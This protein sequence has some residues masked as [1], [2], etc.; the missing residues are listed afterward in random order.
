MIDKLDNQ[1]VELSKKVAEMETIFRFEAVR[2]T[3][4]LWQ[5]RDEARE[6]LAGRKLTD[7]E[8]GDAWNRELESMT[9]FKGF[10]KEAAMLTKFGHVPQ[11]RVRSFHPVI[12][13]AAVTALTRDR[14][15]YRALFQAVY[16]ADADAV[17]ADILQDDD[18]DRSQ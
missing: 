6:A 8:R 16:K 9:D 14:E 2:R 18:D 17:I 11:P 4:C 7:G 12:I 13:A 1:L 5:L 10:P 15:A 3:C